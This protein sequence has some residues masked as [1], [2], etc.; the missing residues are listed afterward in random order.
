VEDAMY[1]VEMK[2]SS[3][4]WREKEQRYYIDRMVAEVDERDISVGEGPE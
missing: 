2:S 4:N 3:P 1:K